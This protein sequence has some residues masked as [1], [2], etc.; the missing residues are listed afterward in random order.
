[1]KVH[2]CQVCYDQ[3]RTVG[4]SQFIARIAAIEVA[5]TADEVDFLNQRAR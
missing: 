3:L 1:M 5:G 4:E 2:H